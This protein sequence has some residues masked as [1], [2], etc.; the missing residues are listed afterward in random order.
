MFFNLTFLFL[1]HTAV[2]EKHVYCLCKMKSLGHFLLEDSNLE[3]LTK[4]FCFSLRQP[5]VANKIIGLF[6]VEPVW[7]ISDVASAVVNYL[8]TLEY[9]YEIDVNSELCLTL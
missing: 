3:V 9:T 8:L 1:G 7:R 2:V 4:W 5:Q 6:L